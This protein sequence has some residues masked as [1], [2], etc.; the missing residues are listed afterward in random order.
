M[1]YLIYFIVIISTVVQDLPLSNE[2]GFIAS[3]MTA[4]LIPFLF[5]FVIVY[6]KKIRVSKFTK[7]L[8]KI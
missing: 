2:F 4:L 7:V 1:G 5:I 6:F 3:S 8:F